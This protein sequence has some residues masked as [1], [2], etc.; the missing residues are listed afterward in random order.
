[1]PIIVVLLLIGILAGLVQGGVQLFN[2]VNASA[3]VIAAILSL[4]VAV[5]ILLTPF[6]LWRRHHLAIHGKK[7]HGQ[8]IVELAFAD[9]SLRLDAL[10]KRGHIQTG[11]GSRAFIFAD[12]DT[13]EVQG[14]GLTLLL[15][16]PVQP[17]HIRPTNAA[18]LRRWHKI[19]RLAASQDL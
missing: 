4:L 17:W 11:Q 8:R 7:Q 12:I 5:A 3:G 6:I 14:R 18:D 19:L 9:G 2:R 13:I 16:N 15:R 10:Q 1:M